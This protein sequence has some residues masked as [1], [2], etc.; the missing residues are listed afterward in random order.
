M[1]GFTRKPFCSHRLA[2]QLRPEAQPAGRSTRE[3][4]TGLGIYGGR[5]RGRPHGG[6]AWAW[7]AGGQGA[8][9]SEAGSLSGGSVDSPES[10]IHG[11]IPHQREHR[12]LFPLSGA[13]QSVACLCWCAVPFAPKEPLGPGPRLGARFGALHPQS[14]WQG[15]G[16]AL[17]E[18]GGDGCAFPH[19]HFLPDGER[20]SRNV[21]ARPG[22]RGDLNGHES[23]GETRRKRL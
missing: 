3:Q 4:R 22:Q 17:G 11:G 21:G 23:G 1:A 19:A 7:G 5:R 8:G 13:L 16:A 18:P 2:R 9:L 15:Q 12:A 20:Q 14:H 10:L 6:A